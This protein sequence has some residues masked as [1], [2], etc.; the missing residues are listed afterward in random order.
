MMRPIVTA[1]VVLSS[2]ALL[3]P[4][5]RG[6]AAPPLVVAA[7]FSLPAP[8]DEDVATLPT[9]DVW[10]AAPAAAPAA[11]DHWVQ[12]FAPYLW[13]PAV[14]TKATVGAQSARVD[15]NVGDTLDGVKD[16]NAAFGGHYEARYDD[17]GVMVDATYMDL[18]SSSGLPG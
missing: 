3:I 10:R 13:I 6:Q 15:S 14:T 4:A 16:L 9:A 12:T 5:A 8:A 7:G 2:A 18:H 11:A 1:A 17:A